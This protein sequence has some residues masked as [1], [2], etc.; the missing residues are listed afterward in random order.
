MVTSVTV[1][2]SENFLIV[3]RGLAVILALPGASA[4][5]GAPCTLTTEAR[6]LRLQENPYFFMEILD[7]FSVHICQACA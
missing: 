1:G 2:I 4:P 7:S 3:S 5:A 6:S